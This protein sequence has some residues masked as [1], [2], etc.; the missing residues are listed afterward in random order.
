M[1]SC[2]SVIRTD[3]PAEIVRPT[4]AIVAGRIWEEAIFEPSEWQ[5]R[6]SLKGATLAGLPVGEAKVRRTEASPQIVRAQKYVD[7][8]R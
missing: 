5:L 3:H 7:E 8:V 1:R 2:R 4:S 6:T